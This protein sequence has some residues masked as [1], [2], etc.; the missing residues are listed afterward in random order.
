MTAESKILLLHDLSRRPDGMY[1]STP[2][3]ITVIPPFKTNSVETIYNL[4][5]EEVQDFKP[6]II[7]PGAIKYYGENNDIPVITVDD[8]E[9][10]FGNL[11]Q[12]LIRALGD[13][14]MANVIDMRW[15][16][17]NYSPHTT[18]PTA[19][20]IKHN[21]Y[22]VSDVSVQSWF[23]GEAKSIRRFPFYC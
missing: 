1:D 7:K 21:E 3:H 18:E 13:V 17:D 16:G 20:F 22:V 12:K 11:H 6:F 15:A 5:K 23:P 8:V 14:G 19:E 10:G 2:S 4:L 9:N